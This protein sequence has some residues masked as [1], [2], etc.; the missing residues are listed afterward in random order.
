LLAHEVG[1]RARI[2]KK[3]SFVPQGTK[4]RK[5]LHVSL[6]AFPDVT[7]SSLTGMLDVFNSFGLLRGLDDSVPSEPPFLAQIVAA[8]SAPLR[9]ASGVIVSPHASISEIEATDIVIIPSVVGDESGEWTAGRYPELVQW[10]SAM[11]ARGAM[12]CSACSG[13]LLLAETGLLAG[14]EATIHWAYAPTFERNFP[15]VRL[16]IDE[17]LIAAGER[18][19]FVMSGASASWHDLVLYLTARHVSP[20]SALAMAKYM[21][22]QPHADGQAPY[23]GFSRRMDHGDGLVRRLQEWLETGFATESPVEAMVKLAGLPERT[24]KRR[25]SRA[26]GYAPLEYVH[27]L[28]I[29]E[30]KRLLERT[31]K[32]VDE[33]SWSVGYLDPAFFRRLFR[34]HTRL[35]PSQYRRK[36][37]LAF[38]P[39]PA[40]SR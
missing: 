27:R 17:V 12:L 21:L 19:E 4:I 30:A 26:T 8:D 11:H 35:A 36:L 38:V 18:Q 32:P 10:L 9:T 40:L 1:L 14:T 20:A 13:V 24:V 37:S 39:R 2:I 5:P 7:A 3:G 28:R 33:I 29:E 22:L 15:R 23:I 6:L 25:F 31:D 34:R 16:R